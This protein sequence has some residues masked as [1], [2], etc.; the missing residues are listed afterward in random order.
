MELYFIT[1]SIYSS[2]PIEKLYKQMVSS[3]RPINPFMST[4]ESIGEIVSIWTLFSHAGYYYLY[5]DL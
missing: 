3:N 1:W 5:N 4:D 2:I